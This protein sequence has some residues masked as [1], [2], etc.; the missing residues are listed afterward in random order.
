MFSNGRLAAV[1]LVGGMVP[2]PS[3]LLVLLGGIALGRA[4][5]GA[6]LVLF[7]GIGMAAALVGTGL[8]LV[9]ARDRFE[10]WNALRVG[11]LAL[12]GQALVLRW[13]RQL[14][15]L[16]AIVVILVGV[17]IAVRSLGTL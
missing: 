17:W 15:L 9:A 12:P 2:S 7:Y 8:L 16:T 1:G 10:R 13:S 5:F 14:P 3:A 6:V 11:H 4:W